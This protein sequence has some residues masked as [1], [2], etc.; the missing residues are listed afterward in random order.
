[1]K[2]AYSLILG[3]VMT[4]FFSYSTLVIHSPSGANIF[5]TLLLFASISAVGYFT[6]DFVVS[7][8][9]GLELSSSLLAGLILGFIY[10]II[11]V[12][13]SRYFL[14]SDFNTVIQFNK[15][16]RLFLPFIV[17]FTSVLWTFMKS[18]KIRIGRVLKVLG[19]YF[20]AFLTSGTL[21]YSIFMIYFL[22]EWS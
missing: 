17:I 14:P 1:M 8:K 20:L 3:A 22:V 13:Y 10:S 4:Y 2:V 9:Y 15:D 5:A 16:S 7:R 12:I 19:Y 6:Y 11:I 21:Y 18:K